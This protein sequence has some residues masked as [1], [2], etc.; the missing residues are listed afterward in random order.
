MRALKPKIILYV[1]KRET[2]S[3]TYNI[4]VRN[5]ILKFNQEVLNYSPFIRTLFTTEHPVDKDKNGI[6]V[7]D[8]FSPEK[9]QVYIK[10]CM[11]GRLESLIPD[12]M[13][14]LMHKLPSKK[15]KN[16]K[17]AYEEQ[18]RTDHKILPKGSSINFVETVLEHS[19]YLWNLKS[20]RKN[21]SM[22]QCQD[23][24]DTYLDMLAIY[25]RSDDYAVTITIDTV[26][27][28]EKFNLQIVFVA[29]FIDG[30]E[31]SIVR[32]GCDLSKPDRTRALVF[33]KMGYASASDI[34]YSL[35]DDNGIMLYRNKVYMT[36]KYKL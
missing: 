23:F 1:T 18:W 3:L 21:C 15:I 28:D 11:T 19:G 12:L 5:T 33:K 10:Y 34:F 22:G 32:T 26:E 8:D 7:F 17:E 24:C 20:V 29:H 30:K 14:Y 25:F 9:M 36:N 16:I 4:N 6:I 27:D 31:P 13:D 35:P 2:M